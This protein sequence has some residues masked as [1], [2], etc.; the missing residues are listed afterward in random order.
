MRLNVGLAS[1]SLLPIAAGGGT[2]P[3]GLH[4]RLTNVQRLFN[5]NKHAA[6]VFNVGMLVRPTTRATYRAGQVALPKNLYSHSDQTS[7]WQTSN[8]TGGSTGWAGRVTDILSAVNSGSFPTG[9]SV[10]GNR[11][12]LSGQST[13]P[14]SISP[15]GGFGL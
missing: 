9:G 14:G 2:V 6:L 10:N 8:P 7:Q 13:R 4:T 3:Y 15:G 1:G 11:L 5:V 12:L